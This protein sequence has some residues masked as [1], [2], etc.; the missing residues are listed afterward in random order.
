M[1]VVLEDNTNYYNINYLQLQKTS[2][3]LKKQLLL[4]EQEATQHQFYQEREREIKLK[5]TTL[6]WWERSIYKS[7]L[8]F[9]YC[10]RG[11]LFWKNKI[12]HRAAVKCS[13]QRNRHTYTALV[14]LL[15]NKSSINAR[16]YRR[17]TR[18]RRSLSHFQFLHIY[19]DQHIVLAWRMFLSKVCPAYSLPLK[20]PPPYNTL[21]KFLK[22]NWLLLTY[23]HDIIIKH[24]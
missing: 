18:R 16:S 15:F 7:F 21:N 2:T 22:L 13:S 3:Q 1:Q 6:H 5:T 14:S 12:T 4:R 17:R 9:T 10:W 11:S 23:E 8:F 24:N 19:Y 20:K